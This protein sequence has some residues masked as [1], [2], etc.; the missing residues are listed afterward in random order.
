LTR[1]KQKLGK[2]GNLSL[3]LREM[4]MKKTITI[5]GFILT[6]S[7][8]VSLIFFGGTYVIF[9]AIYNESVKENSLYV[10]NSLAEL[11]FSSMFQVMNKGWKRWQLEEFIESTKKAVKDTPT[12][13][14]VY[15][16]DLV[17]QAFGPIEQERMDAPVQTAFREGVPLN[18]EREFGVRYIFPLKAVEK[19][20]RC[21]ENAKPGDVLGVIDVRQN[22]A[23]FIKKAENKFILTLVMIAPIPFLMALL[24]VVL[25]NRKLDKSITVLEDNIE[26]VNKVSDLKN[27][28]LKEVNL[29]FA[30]LNNIF[31]KIEELTAKLK[32]VAV[33]KEL[34]EF[35]IKLLEKFVI[36]SEVVKDWRDYVSKLL[37][38]I[39]QV[40]DAYTLFSIFKVD[41]E[42]FDLEVFWRNVPTEKTQSMLE[43]TIHKTLQKNPVFSG[44]LSLNIHHN[45]ADTAKPLPDLNEKDIEVQV[46][47][48]FVET[49]KIGGIVGIGVQAEI[50]K[51]ETRLLVMESILSTLL[52]VVGSVKAI[53]KYTKDLEYYATRDPLTS[54]YNQRVF[55]ELF[56]YEISRAARHGYRFSLL[57]IDLDNFKSVNDTYGHTF[58]DKF[59]QDFA[60]ALRSALRT[61]DILARYGGDEF[62]ALLPETAIEQAISVANRVLEVTNNMTVIAPDGAKVKS[63]V[64][65]GVS[66]YPDHATE[67]KDLFLFADNMMYKAKTEGKSRIGIPTE[68]DVVEVFKRI[69]EKSIIILNAVE[70][71]RIIPFFQPILNVRENR[72]EAVEVLSRIQLEHGRVLGAAEFVEI[73]EKMGVIHKLDYIAMEKAVEGAQEAGY[74]GYIFLNLS[75]RALVLNEFIRETRRIMGE[76]KMPPERIVFEI[77]E[78]DTVKNMNLLEKF[79]NDLKMEGFKLAIDDFG[80]GFSSFHYLKR[81]PIDFVKIEGDFIVNMVKNGKDRAF[82]KSMSMLAQE[83]GIRTVAEYVENEEVLEHVRESGI[84]LAQGYYVGRP[85][86]KLVF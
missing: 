59:L 71:R 15:R 1:V 81:F 39:N 16:G 5:K 66:V 70:E 65:I 79:V 83:L 31:R 10:S 23:P 60:D 40:I 32:S 3:P 73:A 48:L 86:E 63:T 80:S 20:L 13:I 62:V 69:G 41:D 11:T 7:V 27:L 34:L 78:R 37:I 8:M 17:T 85:S 19:C 51:D 72:I 68:E 61:E 42:L 84:D 22:L 64:S 56:E 18:I 77:T 33:D 47:S 4:R 50:V 9:S 38:E 54:L 29:G 2:R 12:A 75:P 76:Y 57:M 30:E 43:R 28:E 45:V 52:N 44:L 58:G 67:Q 74:P 82:V 35:E 14:E 36:T 6:A 53:Y 24:V 21:H 55:W 26:K 46:K 49:P 25:L